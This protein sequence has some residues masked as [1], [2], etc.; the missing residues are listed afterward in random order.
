MAGLYL[1][2]WQQFIIHNALGER[3]DGSWAA[4]EVAMEVSRQNGKGGVFE[5]RELAG[6]FL[7]GEG[8]L[9]HTAHEFSTSLEAFHRLLALIEG[10]QDLSRRVKRVSRA[11]GEE[12]IELITGQ[13]IRYRT[14]TRGGG[15]GF[16]ADFV[17]FDEAMDIPEAMHGALTF[18]LS[19]RPDPQLWYAGSAVDQDT[20]P[21]G[22]VF[23]R[24]RER[25]RK[26]VDPALAYFGWTAGY[27]HPDEV[28]PETAADPEVW[29][30][31]NPGLGIRITTEH[32]ARE[33][34][35]MDHRT[36]CVERLGVG[37]WPSTT[38][39]IRLISSERWSSLKDPES[40]PHGPVC[41]AYDVRP[42]RSTAAILAVGRR[43]DGKIHAE[44]VDH[45][46][47]VG[48]LVPRLA[49][50]LPERDNVGSACDAS[51]PAGAM[52]TPLAALGIY[53]MTASAREYAQACGAFYDIVEN[54][55]LRHRGEHG[56]SNAV[57]GAKT[58]SLGDAWAWSR[59]N[60]AVDISPLVA[61]T[62]GMWGL[63]TAAAGEEEDRPF[64]LADYRIGVL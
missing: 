3:K 4:F 15:R 44:V 63:D 59:R 40:Q 46:R 11:H 22:V 33:Q 50:L 60:S 53:P 14:R 28:D 64:D 61:C 19:A 31:A 42:D 57:K 24:V 51:G 1:D 25:A 13:R 5:V 7:L 43:P 58:R 30:R 52:L 47:G 29:A 16:S 34:R 62:L 9:V 17:A 37:D 27:E 18:T 10:S 49:E 56:L 35:S 23:A 2:P 12:G 48:W 54:D 21:N 6:L 38:E 36:F 55:G 41:F 20:M 8:L 32:V 26:G 45:R 39:A